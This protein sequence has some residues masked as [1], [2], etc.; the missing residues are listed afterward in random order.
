M[1]IKQPEF[2][3][4]LK[5]ILSFLRT[6][7]IKFTPFE[8]IYNNLYDGKNANLDKAIKNKDKEKYP[9]Y[10]N[11]NGEYNIHFDDPSLY[12]IN[13]EENPYELNSRIYIALKSITD[14][15]ELNKN[16]LTTEIKEFYLKNPALFS[17]LLNKYPNQID[18]IKGIFFPIDSLDDAINASNL[19]LLS[20]DASYLYENEREDLL[21]FL[22]S[23]L[24]YMNYRW[25]IPTFEYENLYPLAFWSM[26]WSILPFILVIKRIM[27][28]KTLNV[29]PYHIWEYLESKGFYG[30]KDILTN[31]QALYLYKNINYLLRHRGKQFVLDELEKIF[32]QPYNF[33]LIGKT[34]YHST[35]ER[36][37]N[38]I[39]L[40]EV[41]NTQDD[42]RTEEKKS[43]SS[44]IYDI[45]LQGFDD[46]IDPLY[47]KSIED[48]FKKEKEA[49]LF[50]KFYE[51]SRP[52]SDDRYALQF[53]SF[54]IDTIFYLFSQGKLDFNIN[55][56]ESSLLTTLTSK[57]IVILMLYCFLKY[58]SSDLLNDQH[59][60]PINYNVTKAIALLEKPNLE[61]PEDYPT[62][63]F[64]NGSG[65]KTKDYLNVNDF[66]NKDIYPTSLEDTDSFVN[67]IINQFDFIM[68]Q[69]HYLNTTF[70]MISHSCIKKQLYYLVPKFNITFD[71]GYTTF[72]DFFNAPENVH[73]K[74]FVDSIVHDQD[75]A[76]DLFGIL[77]EY[78][79]PIHDKIGKYLDPNKYKNIFW[80][81]IKELFINMS[82]YNVAFLLNSTDKLPAYTF[83]YIKM[84]DLQTDI[85]N[86]HL[87][88]GG[89]LGC[90]N[91]SFQ[92]D[93]FINSVITEEIS[94]KEKFNMSKE[95]EQVNDILHS[96]FSL[97]TNIDNETLFELQS[98]PLMYNEFELIVEN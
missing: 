21:A 20:Y 49:V 47:I 54:E 93:I 51:I 86:T 38:A 52:I 53:L 29:H 13:D 55:I 91:M 58:I 33:S 66:Y 72:E 97:N 65:Y 14:E 61:Q 42:E 74:S 89:I 45:Y 59:E 92:T 56:H 94:H 6:V 40:P 34:I 24:T 79:L 96:N 2:E 50:T 90:N 95:F 81:K 71:F 84:S 88:G 5:E 12:D 23:F 67:L 26:L 18:L 25:Y 77:L 98:S 4:Y 62:E 3:L 48:R 70:D 63:F 11:L 73:I 44:F 78:I 35:Y 87:I 22:N 30:Y 60:I 41:V 17:S 10:I 57:Q 83:P 15:I 28:I 69:F 75:T 64:V 16:N 9:Y 31:D 1:K 7:T 68:D 36:E 27:N 80:E 46:N 32:L 39:W 8:K 76:I 43:I 85:E 82:S 19:Q 37:Y